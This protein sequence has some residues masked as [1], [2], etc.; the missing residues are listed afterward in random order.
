MLQTDPI[1]CVMATA[2]TDKKSVVPVTNTNSAT[3][4]EPSSSNETKTRETH[5]TWIFKFGSI[6]LPLRFTHVKYLG[7]GSY[8][9]VITAHETKSPE[10]TRR[11][12]IKWVQF[13]FTHIDVK[14]WAQIET[15]Q[16]NFRHLRELHI[17]CQANHP[18]VMH[19]LGIVDSSPDLSMP[20]R[21]TSIVLPRMD[22]D[23]HKLMENYISRKEL[24]PSSS[25]MYMLFGILSGLRY[26]HARR[27]IHRDL[28]PANILCN[29]DCQVKITDFD[30][31]TSILDRKSDGGVPPLSEYVVSRWYRAPEILM[32]SKHPYTEAI[33]MWSFGAL[34]AEMLRR[35]HTPMF[36][37]M[38]PMQTLTLIFHALGHPSHATLVEMKVSPKCL[39]RYFEANGT[40]IGSHV[41]P[42]K[43]DNPSHLWS[44]LAT[45]KALDLL[46]QLLTID[47]QKRLTAD[48]AMRHPC[49]ELTRQQ[50]TGDPFPVYSD[51]APIDLGLDKEQSATRMTIQLALWRYA[52]HYTP[53]LSFAYEAWKKE[54]SKHGYIES[55]PKKGE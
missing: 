9:V 2:C 5:K 12:A 30:L 25:L 39:S 19:A 50:W 53:Q 6:S 38:N 37:G 13:K 15:S 31:A 55:E 10:T 49:F 21:E 7:F 45:P 16:D 40:P 22:T 3:I 26:L 27:I 17:L 43:M 44:P 11:V 33:D 14:D 24:I 52:I 36:P 8:G 54:M 41:P 35:R 4:A 42:K 51:L 1:T 48:A 18:N 32:G 46:S 47:P 29:Q 28:K 23:L 34:M 20:F